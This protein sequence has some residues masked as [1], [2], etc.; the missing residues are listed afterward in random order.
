MLSSTGGREAS[1]AD[2]RSILTTDVITSIE[3]VTPAW[4]TQAL[5]QCCALLTG[6]VEDVEAT[7]DERDLSA[8][9]IH[10]TLR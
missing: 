1:T 3:E 7:S 5:R 8:L 4:L 2:W 10:S 6:H 9:V